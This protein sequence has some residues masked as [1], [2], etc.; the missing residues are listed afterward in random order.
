ML[1]HSHR[2]ISPNSIQCSI[3]NTIQ[4]ADQIILKFHANEDMLN[5]W[6]EVKDMADSLLVSLHKILLRV[7]TEPNGV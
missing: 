2:S 3:I 1:N 5:P 6:L 7:S 4:A